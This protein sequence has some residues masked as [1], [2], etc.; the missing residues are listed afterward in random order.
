MTTAQFIR[1]P[2]PEVFSAFKWGQAVPFEFLGPG[3]VLQR[4]RDKIIIIAADNTI[5]AVTMGIWAVRCDRGPVELYSDAEFL[6]AFDVAP[7]A[8]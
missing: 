5:T 7:V 4:E 2:P 1:R 3:E 8:A 6:K